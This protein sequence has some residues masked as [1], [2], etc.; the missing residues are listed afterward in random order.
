MSTRSTPCTRSSSRGTSRTGSA[1]RSTI[2]GDARAQPTIA[3]MALFGRP[4]E[5]DDVR[6]A[7]WTNWF[8]RQHPF[9]LASLPLSV[10][11]LTHAGT[12]WVDEIA[13]IVLGVL[14]LRQLA[15]AA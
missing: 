2:S 5:R 3:P 4:S 8:Q 7:N 1:C 13:G 9:A 6:A 12:L 10:F 14:A 11:S 15:R